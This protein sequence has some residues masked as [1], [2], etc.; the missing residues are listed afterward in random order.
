M[1]AHCQYPK[2]EPSKANPA[3]DCSK[4]PPVMAAPLGRTGGWLALCSGCAP[5]RQD[6]IPIGEVPEP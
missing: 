1:R 4:T 3:G 2:V 5:Y 6:A